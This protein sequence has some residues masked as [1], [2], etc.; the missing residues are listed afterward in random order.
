MTSVNLKLFVMMIFLPTLSDY[1]MRNV[2]TETADVNLDIGLASGTI[3]QLIA[4]VST[5]ADV[6]LQCF[7]WTTCARG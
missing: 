2:L 5:C 6:C 4:Q 7:S 1:F 3:V